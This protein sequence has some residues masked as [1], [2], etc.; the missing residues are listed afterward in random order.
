MNLKDRFSIFVGR[1]AEKLLG[2]KTLANITGLDLNRTYTDEELEAIKAH[3]DWQFSQ[4]ITSTAILS[5]GM[6]LSAKLYQVMT[7]WLN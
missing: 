2:T 4:M 6:I 1:R 3:W 5:S 7:W